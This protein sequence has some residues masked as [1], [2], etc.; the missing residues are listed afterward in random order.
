MSKFILTEDPGK[1]ATDITALIGFLMFLF[2]HNV[3]LLFSFMHSEWT[4]DYITFNTDI[5]VGDN[6]A[7]FQHESKK[8]KAK[9]ELKHYSYR[10]QKISGPQTIIGSRFGSYRRDE[11]FTTQLSSKYMEAIYTTFDFMWRKD[12][13]IDFRRQTQK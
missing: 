8:R 11:W 6:I 7:Y 10:W 12:N 2:I 13:L 5:D 3:R 4:C 9:G 1:S